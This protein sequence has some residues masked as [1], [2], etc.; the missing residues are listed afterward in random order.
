MFDLN[1]A[2]WLLAGV[3]V[4]LLTKIIWTLPSAVRSIRK[5]VRD[6]KQGMAELEKEFHERNG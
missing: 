4:G 2:E 6:F 5:S 3:I 1:L